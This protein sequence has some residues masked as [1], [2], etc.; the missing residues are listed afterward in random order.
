MSEVVDI[1]SRRKQA[2]PEIEP[3]PSDLPARLRASLAL[4]R[5][6]AVLTVLAVKYP[7][8]V[9]LALENLDIIEAAIPAADRER[10]R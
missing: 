3:I 6:R 1:A 2:T 9:G 7:L 5:V 10:D 8:T 4:I